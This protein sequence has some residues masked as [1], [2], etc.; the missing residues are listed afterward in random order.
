M[1]SSSVLSELSSDSINW[2]FCGLDPII[3]RKWKSFFFVFRMLLW[4]YDVFRMIASTC[5]IE[6]I[7]NFLIGFENNSD[8]F[9]LLKSSSWLFVSLAKYSVSLNRRFDSKIMHVYT[10][11]SVSCFNSFR[12][13]LNSAYPRSVATNLYLATLAEKS[14]VL[15][16]LFSWNCLTTKSIYSTISFMT[17]SSSSIANWLFNVSKSYEFDFS[18]DVWIKLFQIKISLEFSLSQSSLITVFFTGSS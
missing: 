6:L 5:L 14:I 8:S 16:K 3:I 18:L 13:C 9:W 7:S 11:S 4:L 10:S 15:P 2:T 12:N 1:H 17:S